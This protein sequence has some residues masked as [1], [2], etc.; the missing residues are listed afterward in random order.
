MQYTVR[1]KIIHAQKWILSKVKW[2]QWDKTQS[3]ELLGLFICVCSSLCTIVAHNTAQNRPDNFPS[4][5]PDNHHCSDDDYLREGGRRE[6]GERVKVIQLYCCV[7][8]WHWRANM[9]SATPLPS[10]VWHWIK[11]GWGQCWVIFPGCDQCLE[12]PSVFWHYWSADRKH[13]CTVNNLCN[14]RF[15]SRTTVGRRLRSSLRKWPLKQEEEL[16]CW[17]SSTHSVSTIP[18]NTGNLLEFLITPGKT[19]SLLEYFLWWLCLLGK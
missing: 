18:G 14:L 7:K 13:I 15:S 12:L 5:P 17:H 1:H 6:G 3:G 11:K 19:G 4:C 2:A 8:Y 10:R 16:C 9:K